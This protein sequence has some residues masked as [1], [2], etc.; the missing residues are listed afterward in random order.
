MQKEEY[1]YCCRQLLSTQLSCNNELGPFFLQLQD[2]FS[3]WVFSPWPLSKDTLQVLPRIKTSY[4]GLHSGHNLYWGN[5]CK[6][7]RLTIYTCKTR[8]YTCKKLNY[9][10]KKLNYTCKKLNYTRKK[11]TYTCKK[12]NCT[13]CCCHPCSHCGL[14][15]KR[16]VLAI[17]PVCRLGLS[18][19]NTVAKG[20]STFFRHT[21][22]VN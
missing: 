12:R 7:S 15:K 3:T 20:V 17:C 8:N 1:H 9:T 11:L 22:M 2:I 18:K 5:I 16:K 14:E 4:G 19:V 13:C 6:T 21:R 10:C